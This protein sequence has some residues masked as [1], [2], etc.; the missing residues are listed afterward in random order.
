MRSTTNIDELQQTHNRLKLEARVAQLQAEIQN[1][2]FAKR[3]SEICEAAEMRVAD[4]NAYL[5]DSP[6]FFGY[7]PNLT[8]PDIMRQTYV[9]SINDRLRGENYPIFRTEHELNSIRGVARVITNVDETAVGAFEAL[10]NYTVGTG[11][12]YEVN[13]KVKVQRAINCR[14]LANTILDE[15]RQRDKWRLKERELVFRD[16]RDGEFFVQ[17]KP[18]GGGKAK[19]RIIDPPKVT[20]PDNSRLLDDFLGFARLEWSF[21]IATEPNENETPL[22]YFVNWDGQNNW[23]VF[24]EGDIVHV[25]SNVDDEIKRGLS[26]GYAIYRR[27]LAA[28]DIYDKAG[29]GASN[30][31]AIAFIREWGPGVTGDQVTGWLDQV[32]TSRDPSTGIRRVSIPNGSTID[33]PNGTKFHPG[34]MG[35]SNA[36]GLVEIAEAIYTHAGVRWNMPRYLIT[37]DASNAAFAS[38]LVAESPFVKNRTAAQAKYAD[39]FEQVAWRVLGAA[40][41]AGLFGQWGVVKLSQLKQLIDIDAKAPSITVRN[42]LEETQLNQTLRQEG[43]LSPQTWAQREDLDY[44]SEQDLIAQAPARPTQQA[45][46]GFGNNPTALAPG[47][48]QPG[49]LTESQSLATAARYLWHGYP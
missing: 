25:K 46:G 2:E 34:P 43:I 13:E 21:G 19:T 16:P 22:A 39:A 41:D 40:V 31:A 33:V 27:L 8:D 15:W 37:G 42:R 36:P 49:Q 26:D 28:S 32:A 12:S 4:R 18:I 3:H 48:P 9:A 5:H 35:Q 7:M 30:Q 38:T 14:E 17:V 29:Q 24:R 20:E 11:Y 45:P 6:G 47:A 44:D 1:W 23:D 10:R